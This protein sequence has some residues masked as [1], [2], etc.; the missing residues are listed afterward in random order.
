MW[1]SKTKQV[2]MQDMKVENSSLLISFL[3]KN[4]EKENCWSILIWEIKNG[5]M[6]SLSEWWEQWSTY[7]KVDFSFLR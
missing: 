3:I 5:C 4:I 6:T 2:F 7:L 1:I